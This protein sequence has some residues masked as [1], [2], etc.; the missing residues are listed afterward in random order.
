LRPS[1]QITSVPL[2]KGHL[3]LAALTTVWILIAVRIEERDLIAELGAR[4]VE[5]KQQV[6][7]LVPGPH[8]R[9]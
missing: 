4:C 3:L 9:Q 5:Y 2:S 8:G 7:M 6:P 1:P